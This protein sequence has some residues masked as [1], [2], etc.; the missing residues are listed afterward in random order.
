MSSV[1]KIDFDD[2]MK[3]IARAI[4]KDSDI[5]NLGKALGFGQ[6]DIGRAIDKNA[7]Q[8]GDY[9][10]TLGMLRTW[11]N[12]QELQNQKEE[13]R[14]ALTTA[15]L[16]NLADQYLS[17]P[18]PESA[19]TTERPTENRSKNEGND[20]DIPVVENVCPPSDEA[21]ELKLRD[22]QEEVLT[23]ALKGQNAM[24]VLPTGTGKT[25]V[26]IALI[27][28]RF[29]ARNPVGATN[30][31][32]QKSVFVVNKVPLMKQQKD[33][34]L[35]YLRGKCKVAGTSGVESN[36]VPLD[37]LIDSN[38]LTVLTAEKLVNALKDKNIK[39]EL[40][41]IALACPRRMSSLPEI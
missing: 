4:H 13:L 17:I 19:K 8:G 9:M 2:I 35:K 12:G 23:P 5:D 41:D 28:R 38:D 6:G 14:S 7:Q 40:S 18:V 25:E 29:L 33:R 39:L 20:E 22:Y 24:V 32:R 37:F 3:D 27:S 31:R 1:V 10:G 16:V 21:V 11:Q 34:C 30:H 36:P 26:A 15:G